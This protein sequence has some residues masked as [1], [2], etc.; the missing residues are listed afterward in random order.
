MSP[1]RDFPPV[2][3]IAG[4]DHFLARVLASIDSFHLL[5]LED[6]F[7]V[8][9]DIGDGSFGSVVLARVR[10]AGASVARRGTVV[11]IKTMKKSFE[12]FSP[13]LELREVVFLRTLPPHSHLVPALDIFLDPFSKKLH[14]C[15]EFME[16]NLYQLMKARDHKCLD[17]PSVKSILFQIMRGLEH[18]HAHGFFHR[19]IKP[20]NIL[21]TTSS[22]PDSG[23]SFRRY[24]ALVTPPST[25]PAYTVKIADFG[26]ARETHS[27][28]PYTTYVSTRWYRAPEVLLRA[29]QYSAPVDIWAVGAM[30][31][32]VATLKPLFPGVNEVDQVWRVCEIMG[33]PGNWYNKSGARVGGGE[34]REGSRLAG[35]LG[36]SFPKM[37]PHSMDTILQSPQWPSSLSQF[38]TWCLMWDPKNRPTSTQALAHDFFADAVDPLRPKSATSRMLGRKQSD[39]SRGKDST[40]TTPTS[41]KPSWFR[42]SLIGPGDNTV[43]GRLV[44]GVDFGTTFSGVAAVHT[45]T[46]DE[47]EIIK[48]WPGGNGITS[49][50]VPTELAYDLAAD[51]APGT[52]PG[53]RWGF[54]FKAEESR[55]RCIKLFLD[56]SQK[57][58]FYVSPLETA[59]QLKRY[60]K[61]V[62]DA[63]GDYL[64]QMHRHT[65]DTLTRRYGAGLMASTQVDFVL[66]C[67][68]VWSDAAK[69]T[70]LQAA[71][72][73]GMGARSRIQMISEPEAAAVYTLKCLQ[74]NQLSV[75]DNVIVCDG[76]GGTVDLIAYKILSLKPPRV[77]E[78]AVGTG[79][80]CGSAFLNFGFEE[81]V[82]NRLGPRR[83]DEMKAR[84]GK[85]W[86]M[87]LRYFEDVVKRS[88][89]EDDDQEV[90]IPFPGLADDEEVGLDSGFLVMTA[91]Q[92]KA[93][94]E[95]VVK[96]VCELV[97]GQVD[98]LR[99]K[100]GVVSGIILVGGFGQSDYL[101]R[102]LRSHFSTSAAPPPYS[103]R[104][105]QSQ[106]QSQSHAAAAATHGSGSIEVMQPAYAWTAV[107]RGA[108]LRGLEE[109]SMVLSRKARMHYGTSYATVYDEDKHSVDERYWSPLWERWMVSHRMQWHIHKGDAISPLSPVGFHY[110]RNFRPG[111]SLVVTDD[112]IACEA[113]E[114]P[115]SYSRELVHVCTLTTDLRAV[116]RS[117]FT[118]LTT[119]QDLAFDN[120]DFTLEM[121]VDSAGLA[122]EL[123]VD[124]V[125]YGRVD[126]EF[127]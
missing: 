29:G 3:E 114:P 112:L 26:L 19:D 28:L 60:N 69:N 119:T 1:C 50:K 64:T 122:F 37:A 97:Q 45:S 127:H 59:A 109:G 107:V 25:P 23:N 118:R 79:G 27:K 57:L 96:E 101:Y 72:R 81:H 63:V 16:G 33:S 39:N 42:K 20:E 91:D 2:W 100:G 52:A 12:S 5:A 113:D 48:T 87:G 21:V 111:Q 11:A 105:S 88:F 56:R 123:K 117:L 9:K 92:I 104:A 85:T 76:G 47:V 31:V 80:L 98:S 44:V 83:F 74:P 67:P 24:S 49:D 66:T 35:K 4:H 90:N 102:R 125:R 82:R 58:P 34:W 99:A 61:T 13:C 43:A 121:M 36:F 95:P 38:V 54:Q 53:V 108:V 55:L 77:E 84:K 30:A 94:F 120:L 14:I 89:H 73:A 41:S 70:T 103:E 62:V 71:E 78:S 7:E 32:E 115:A 10:T 106:S 75:G 65:M 126:A 110:T 51:A 8:L 68:A 22:H 17:N 15:M 93:I 46:P 6:R 18:I 124:G 86:Q 116:P 40:I